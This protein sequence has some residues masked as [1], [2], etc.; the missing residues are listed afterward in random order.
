MGKLGNAVDGIQNMTKAF[1]IDDFHNVLGPLGDFIKNNQE[2]VAASLANVSNITAQIASG[3]GT[4][5]KLIYNDSL[6]S[7]AMVI[8]NNLHPIE[9]KADNLF[10]SIN[11]VV[12]NLSAGQGTLGKLLTDDTLHRQLTEGMTNLD[13]ILLKVNQG[14][15]TVAR[16]I[17]EPEM[18]KNIKLTMQKV[19]KATE[20]L[21]DQGPLSIISILASPLGL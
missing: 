6:Y 10:A 4:V 18:Y 1:P 13:Q 11:L 9:A 2:S 12:T 16:V 19:D 3:Q 8:V 21:E 7:N 14:T 20:S 17:N 15:G 5:G